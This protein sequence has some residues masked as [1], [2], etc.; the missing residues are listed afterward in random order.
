MTRLSRKNRDYD[1]MGMVS[2][3]GILDMFDNQIK[4]IYRIN[5]EEYDYIALKMSDSELELIVKENLCYSEKKKVLSL[6]NEYL[7][8]LYK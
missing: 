3:G 5:D 8:K 6:L 1:E 4:N 7:N 2:S